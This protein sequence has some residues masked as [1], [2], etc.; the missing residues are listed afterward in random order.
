MIR[1]P[2]RST[3]FPYTTLFRSEV[4]RPPQRSAALRDADRVHRP[5]GG[6]RQVDPRIAHHREA[7]GG[8][9]A[10][11]AAERGEAGAGTGER[12]VVDRVR[13]EQPGVA[14]VEQREAELEIAA[15]PA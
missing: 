9:D 11:V 1:R 14:I 15:A 3:L 5:R 12:L 2:P 6:E 4:A 8:A 7:D 13:H 10:V